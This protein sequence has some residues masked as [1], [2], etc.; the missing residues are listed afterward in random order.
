MFYSY[1]CSISAGES[2]LITGGHDAVTLSTVKRYN[3][4][5]LVES[6]PD[7]NSARHSHGCTSY[8]N[9]DNKQVNSIVRFEQFPIFSGL[10]FSAIENN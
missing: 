9:G 10:S 3:T 5:G 1:A 8:V 2:V 6:L 7:M 4:G